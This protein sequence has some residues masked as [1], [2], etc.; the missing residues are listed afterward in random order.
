M[1]SVSSHGRAQ[2]N[3]LIIERGVEL[4]F[5]DVQHQPVTA[6]QRLPVPFQLGLHVVNSN[7]KPMIGVYGSSLDNVP[8]SDFVDKRPVDFNGKESEI[9]HFTY[10]YIK[11]KL[12]KEVFDEDVAMEALEDALE[13]K[14]ITLEQYQAFTN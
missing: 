14:R 2:R 3:G 9:Y 13:R 6:G 7:G 8:S 4:A 5:S 12:E 1:P 10:D 11:D